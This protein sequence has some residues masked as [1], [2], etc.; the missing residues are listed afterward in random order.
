LKGIF[1]A[2][3][4]SVLILWPHGGHSCFEVGYQDFSFGT[5]KFVLPQPLWVLPCEINT[6]KNI[7]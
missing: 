5:C 3:K 7:F 1:S 6:L 2:Y 4:A